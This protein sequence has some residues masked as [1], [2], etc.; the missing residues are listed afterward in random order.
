[1]TDFIARRAVV[2]GAAGFIGSTLVDRLATAG[3]EVVGYD[4]FTTG[5][6]RFLEKAN[7]QP[8][9]KLVEGDVLDVN[10]LIAAMQGADIVF[11]LAAN[12]DVR[13][14]LEH[15]RKDLESTPNQN[16]ND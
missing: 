1:M 7:R 15:P 5:F 16:F 14:G 12:A 3:V 13:L 8:S 9:F 10:R 2:T 6:H 4:D 11:H